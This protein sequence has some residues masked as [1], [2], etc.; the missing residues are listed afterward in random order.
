MTSIVVLA[1]A[2]T[3]LAGA[4]APP[5]SAQE[6][7]AIV[8]RVVRVAELHRHRLELERELAALTFGPSHPVVVEVRQRLDAVLSQIRRENL[9]ASQ[10]DGRL[11]ADRRYA[12]EHQLANMSFGRDHPV[13][14]KA[15]TELTAVKE[16]QRV[17]A[18]A[19][20]SSGVEAELKA[21]VAAKPSTIAPYLELAEMYALAGRNEEAAAMLTQA[22]A[23]L[24]QAGAR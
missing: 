10:A 12:L 7:N 13:R 19:A 6:L 1:L 18:V 3:G 5:Q 2:L 11:L 17:A 16:Q 22:L 8:E 20:L 14:R 9:A 24:K 23:A 21:L 4:P 15:Q